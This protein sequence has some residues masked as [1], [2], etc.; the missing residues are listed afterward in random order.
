MKVW[1][2]MT[3]TMCQGQI[4]GGWLEHEDRSITP[5]V[6]STARAAAEALL[7]DR[8]AW[9]ESRR[10]NFD[11]Y[12]ENDEDVFSEALD[13]L[14]NYYEPAEITGTDGAAVVKF[15]NDETE[16]TLA[17]LAVRSGR[18]ADEQIRWPG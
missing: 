11:D 4:I 3:E 16:W 9:L 5:C 10:D 2:E 1:I 17:E 7:E 12:E 14:Q 6:Y 8:I 15:L 18:N 13:D